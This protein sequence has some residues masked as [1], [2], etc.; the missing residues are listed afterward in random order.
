VGGY[1]ACGAGPIPPHIWKPPRNSQRPS[2]LEDATKT[3]T[4]WYGL[5]QGDFAS[6]LKGKKVLELG[7]GD[8]INSLIM[9]AL[10]AQVIANDISPVSRKCIRDAALELGLD[11][12]QTVSGLI[13]E[14]AFNENSFDFVIGKAFLHHL[15]HEMENVVLFQTSKMLKPDGEVRFFEPAVNSQF[16]DILR[17]ITPVPGRP[18]LLAKSAFKRWRD[19]DPHPQRDNSSDHFIRLGQQYFH[20]VEIYPVGS[21]ERFCRLFPQGRMNRRFRRWTHKADEKLPMPVRMKAARSQ[22]IV[23]S[24]PI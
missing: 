22:L 23:F 7:C 21:I 5:Y 20:D 8:G 13:D 1:R 3:D 24:L 11:N 16:L 10:G 14:L 12:I 4:S 6:R 2:F 15:T 9:A 17:W 18:S 19:S